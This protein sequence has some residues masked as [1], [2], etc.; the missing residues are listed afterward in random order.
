MPVR[1]L[2][3]GILASEG[4]NALDWA[5]ECFYRRLMSVVDD[6]GCF[7]GR[8]AVI[9]PRC[10]PLKLDQ[11]RE[12]DISR[13]IAMC[14]KAGVITLYHVEAKPYVYMPKLGESK[15][16]SN[17]MFPVPPNHPWAA[18]APHPVRTDAHGCAQ[19]RSPTSPF[20]SSSSSPSSS[21]PPVPPEGGKREGR[22]KPKGK[23]DI[24]GVIARLQ[25][26][27][28]ANGSQ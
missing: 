7:D 22:R 3:E 9:R 24:S 11:V 19:M 13:W 14:V 28:G 26:S 23:A 25:A 6:Y 16:R 17:P 20:P 5:A 12:A 27:G 18:F 21:L 4:V 1:R 2:R 15:P 8:P 10:Y